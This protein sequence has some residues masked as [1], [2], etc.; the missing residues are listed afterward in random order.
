MGRT[1]QETNGRAPDRS[2]TGYRSGYDRGD[3]GPLDRGHRDTN[4]NDESAARPNQDRAPRGGDRIG[5]RSL[6]GGS[7]RAPRD[8]RDR[9]TQVRDTRS[10]PGLVVPSAR[11]YRDTARDIFT[12]S[13][14]GRRY[15]RG[16]ALRPAYRYSDTHFGLYFPHGY[17][18]YPHYSHTY[19]S[20]S[21]IVSPYHFYYGICPPYIRRDYVYYRPPRVVYIEVPV[22]VGNAYYGY[23]DSSYYLDSGSWWRDDRSTDPAVRRAIEDLEDAFRYSDINRLV[24]LT[25]PDTDIAIFTRGQY[26][27]SLRPNDYLDMTRDFMVG[28]DTLRFDVFRVR[29]RSSDVYNLTA[30]HTYRGRDGATRVVYLSFVLERV[31]RDWV[32]TQVDTAPDR[33]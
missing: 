22:Y 17:C 11:P 4:R 8:R 33:L 32:I 29:R 25:D 3:R 28:A 24:N 20:F 14:E 21:V 23:D 10:N 15:A 16:I 7:D 26:Q 27:Y 9:E 30:K 1:G 2:E 6:P 31:Y 5:D 12:R 13:A 18:Y 19:V